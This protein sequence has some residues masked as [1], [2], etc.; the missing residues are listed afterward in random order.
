MHADA[1]RY[2]PEWIGLTGFNKTYSLESRNR[3]LFEIPAL[4]LLILRN[5]VNPDYFSWFFRR[6]SAFIGG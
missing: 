4:I 1:R 3:T 6:V 5:H 2:K